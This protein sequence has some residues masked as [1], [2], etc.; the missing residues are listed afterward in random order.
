MKIQSKLLIKIAIFLIILSSTLVSCIKDEYAPLPPEDLIDIDSNIYK[1]IQFGDQIWMAED[2]RTTRLNDSTKIKNIH[3]YDYY[4][5]GFNTD[6]ASALW[7][8]N[9]ELAYSKYIVEARYLGEVD[10][11][12]CLYNFKAITSTKLCPEGWHV[13][14]QND[15]DRLV[16][17]LGG[18]VLAGGKLKSP[19][20]WGYPNYGQISYDGFSAKPTGYIDSAGNFSEYQTACWWSA[21]SSPNNEALVLKVLEYSKSI[22]LDFFSKNSGISVR[23][24]KD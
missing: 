21:T 12:V 1:T 3:F 14:T 7:K 15:W 9:Q 16:N 10:Y 2:L 17:Q 20:P 19:E 5:G 24:I 18:Y 4:F 13:P 6:S 22:K 8:N 11:T 23:C